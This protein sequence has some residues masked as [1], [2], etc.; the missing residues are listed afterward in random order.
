MTEKIKVKWLS[1]Q[2]KV[3][4]PKDMPSGTI[5][6]WSIPDF[7]KGSPSYVTRDSI[8]SSK[9]KVFP[10]DVLLSKIVPHIRRAWI[11]KESQYPQYASTEWMTFRSE[12]VLPE[13]LQFAMISE[14]FNAEMLRNANGMGSL[15]R[16]DPEKVGD[17]TIALPS[18]EKQKEIINNIQRETDKLSKLLSLKEGIVRRLASYRQSL[19]T[20]AV[21]KGLDPDAPMKDSDIPWIGSMPASWNKNKI[22]RICSTQSGGTPSS[23]NKSFYTNGKHPWIRTTDLNDSELF[24]APIK[25]TDQAIQESA[26]K[27]VP[28]NSVLIAMYGGKGTI[29]KH[30]LLRFPSTI[31][32]AV[33]AVTPNDTLDPEYLYFLA[34]AY[35]PFWM[36]D[37]L[38]T[39][40]DP[41]IS[42]EDIKNWIIPIPP[43]NEQRQIVTFCQNIQSK[44]GLINQKNTKIIK[45]LSEYRISQISSVIN[46]QDEQWL[47]LH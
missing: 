31:N 10:G 40:K 37:A 2:R 7:D 44:V 17:Q 36:I 3:V 45:L 29:G 33:C 19:I 4:D 15:K 47:Q 1:V 16:A 12:K 26:C 11:V 5:E 34:K 46:S 8:G 14:E 13:Y 6:L 28:K 25:I 18:L 39:R 9:K 32:Q 27:Y 24:S 30:A 42:Q 21:T 22:S 43:L 20:C 35:R 23:S 41:N 38:S